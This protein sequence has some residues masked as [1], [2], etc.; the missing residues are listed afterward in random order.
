MRQTRKQ[1]DNFIFSL[2]DMLVNEDC[3][4]WEKR[5]VSVLLN[6]YSFIYT[7]NIK[8]CKLKGYSFED[9]QENRYKA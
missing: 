7:K 5:T 8:D 3:K 4:E 2:E 9:S 6:W 1:R